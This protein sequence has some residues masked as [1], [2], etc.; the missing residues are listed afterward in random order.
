MSSPTERRTAA[1]A[2]AE[3]PWHLS[4]LT[5]R[6]RQ[7]AWLLA[8]GYRKRE[9]AALLAVDTGWVKHDRQE[10]YRRLGVFNRQQLTVYIRGRRP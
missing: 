1:E 2:S 8:E 6:Q 10:V 3:G 5:P 9:I 7:V 4:S